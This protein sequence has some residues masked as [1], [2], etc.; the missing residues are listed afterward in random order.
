MDLVGMLHN[1]NVSQIAEAELKIDLSGMEKDKALQ[2]LDKEV[3]KAKARGILSIYVSFDP[4]KAG[5][6]ETLFQPVMRY[7][8]VEKWNGYLSHAMPLMTE[9]KGGVFAVFK[10]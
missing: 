5:N 3:S 10:V 2:L 7:F 6:G 4:A 9:E 1:S 8:K